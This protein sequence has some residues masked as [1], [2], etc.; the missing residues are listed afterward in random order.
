MQE[1]SYD[2]QCLAVPILAPHTQPDCPPS[3]C[4]CLCVMPASWAQ[5]EAHQQ[6]STANRT[7]S[8]GLCSAHPLKMVRL[9]PLPNPVSHC[10]RLSAW[11][12]ST[13][14]PRKWLLWI[15][16]QHLQNWHSNVRYEGGFVTS[17]VEAPACYPQCISPILFLRGSLKKN[18]SCAR[19]EEEKSLRVNWWAEAGHKVAP[20]PPATLMPARARGWEGTPCSHIMQVS[21]APGAIPGLCGPHMTATKA[22]NRKK[23]IG[24]AHNAAPE[25]GLLFH[26]MLQRSAPLPCTP[27]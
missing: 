22:N 23:Q 27:P 17:R 16:R 26:F 14:G 4:T 12:F 13:S 18:P 24:A 20:G 10:P 7:D 8:P 9:I 11:L 15:S 19:K 6:P 21:R 5:A 2:L 3:P 1:L 25:L